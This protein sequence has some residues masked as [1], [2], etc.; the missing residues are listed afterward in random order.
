MRW[1]GVMRAASQLGVDIIENWNNGFDIVRGKVQGIKTKLGNIKPKKLVWL[2][3]VSSLVAQKAGLKLPM[4]SH[5]LQAFVSEPY[6]PLINTV[7]T[8]GAGHLYQ[9][10]G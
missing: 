5:V 1:R 8:Y 4:E 6:K 10:I 7:V 3:L 9:S 2:W